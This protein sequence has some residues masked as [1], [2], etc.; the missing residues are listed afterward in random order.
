[1]SHP[2]R[3][4]N[5]SKKKSAIFISIIISGLTLP[6][7]RILTTLCRSSSLHLRMNARLVLWTR[8][9]KNKSHVNG[10]TAEITPHVEETFSRCGQ[11]CLSHIGFISNHYLLQS[12]FTKPNQK[13]KTVKQ[14]VEGLAQV[15]TEWISICLKVRVN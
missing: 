2:K 1:M 7:T 5:L 14:N 3:Y 10:I 15:T 12:S 4:I 9:K 6:Q 11:I 13:E 8:R